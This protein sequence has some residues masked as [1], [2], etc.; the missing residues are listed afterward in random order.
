MRK[1]SEISYSRVASAL[2]VGRGEHHA[3]AN[4]VQL[5]GA[6]LCDQRSGRGANQKPLR[7]RNPRDQIVSRRYVVTALRRLSRGLQWVQRTKINGSD[8]TETRLM[9][10]CW[11]SS[12]DMLRDIWIEESRSEAQL[13]L[14]PRTW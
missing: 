8:L 10:A 12:S 11:S 5:A 4:M 2:S 3:A 13:F 6:V 14:L 1:S 9:E 7:T